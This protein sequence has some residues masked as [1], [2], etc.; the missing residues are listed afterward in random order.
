MSKWGRS[1][2]FC[3]DETWPGGTANL[4]IYYQSTYTDSCLLSVTPDTHKDCLL[5]KKKTFLIWLTHETWRHG[6]L[7]KADKLPEHWNI[8]LKYTG[9]TGDRSSDTCWWQMAT[10]WE[11]A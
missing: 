8:P 3:L 7:K 4:I 9:Q 5:E 11:K 1:F 6:L 2:N 10:E